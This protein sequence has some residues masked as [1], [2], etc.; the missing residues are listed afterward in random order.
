[1]T[2]REPI[3]PKIQ[4][5]GIIGDCRSAALVSRRGS[6]EWLCWPRF[7][8]PSIFAALLDR[9]RGGFWSIAPTGE[10]ETSRCYVENSNV[11]ETHF[12]CATGAAT[13]TDLMPVACEEHKRRCL[14]PAHELLREVCC[15]RGQIE[16]ESIFH[17]RA[18]YGSSAVRFRDVHGLGLR[19]DVGRGAYWLRSN[20]S[21]IV[22]NDEARVRVTLKQGDTLQCSL[23]YSEE[24]P[25]VLPLLGD[26][27]ERRIER[28]VD[29]WQAWA[30][31]C[32]YHGPHRREV[33]RSA[34]AL[35]LMAYAPSGAI[36]A[37]PTTSLPEIIGDTLNWDYRYCW[38]RD[39][40]FTIRALLGLGYNDEAESFHNWL[41]LATRITHPELRVLYNLHG[42]LTAHE[43]CFDHLTGYRG[44]RP[45]RVGNA[46][47]NQL[48]L[49]V[50]GEVACAAD[51]FARRNGGLDRTM[52][53]ALIGFGREL[54]GKWQLPDEGIW[55][56]RGGRALHTFSRL[57][58]WAAFDRL[59]AMSQDGLLTD[60]PVERFAEARD[61]ARRDIH[62]R[63]WSEQ[64]QSYVSV[65]DGN[66][67]DAALLLIPWY[68]FERADSERMRKTHARIRAELGAGDALLYRYKRQPPE[69]AF[70]VCSFW[71][72]EYLALGG[73]TLE[74]AEEGFKQVMR[75][76]SDLGLFSEEISPG[77]GDALGNFPQAFT[78]LG[79]I[80]AA[81]ALERAAGRAE[82]SGRAA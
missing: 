42:D 39:A 25:A 63:G 33:V 1:V 59:T 18:N 6:V 71:E 15:T 21:F 76:Q 50:Y 37:A 74:Q 70:G 46:A 20:A 30:G 27:C 29:W 79:V 14:W 12:E 34:L 81:L 41:L 56:P 26:D 35:K 54:L 16:I 8:S 23:S 43:R 64:M 58:C 62:T 9:D 36:I 51:I 82:N 68:G 28:S 32:A 65:F 67:L 31:K 40:S 11:L 75:Y 47:K 61:K 4:E 72:I 53:N 17:P 5:Y 19:M 7:D 45:V 77:T 48:Q 38:L 10:Y 24:A 73:G 57:M 2:A 69:G 80:N 44:S 66:R 22:R 3:F 52:Q 13:L 49:D 78:H 55:E 60:A